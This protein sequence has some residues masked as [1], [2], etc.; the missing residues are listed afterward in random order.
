MLLRSNLD[1]RDW[2]REEKGGK[3]GAA[4]QG[5]GATT[6]TPLISFTASNTFFFFHEL[7]HSGTLRG[8][9]GKGYDELVLGSQESQEREGGGGGGGATLPELGVVI[10]MISH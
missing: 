2:S 3:S 8:Q 7:Y 9:W 4:G 1:A 10:T 5:L 6:F